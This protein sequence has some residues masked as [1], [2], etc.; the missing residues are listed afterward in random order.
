MVS[1]PTAGTALY[2]GKRIIQVLLLLILAL[3]L[4]VALAFAFNV[5]IKLSRFAPFISHIV[6]SYSG[7]KVHIDGDIL[8]TL[9][10]TTELE[11]EGIRWQEHDSDKL[12][13]L[14]LERGEA[15]IDVW[16]LFGPQIIIEKIAL[17]ALDLNLIVEKGME[18]NI[19]EVDLIALLEWIN[20]RAD[21]IPPFIADDIVLENVS[22]LFLAPEKNLK[23]Q[24][25]FDHINAAW[26]WDS[27]LQ[28]FGDGVLHDYDPYPISIAAK[29]G[30]FKALGVASKDW[31][32]SFNIAGNVAD[33]STTLTLSAESE[34]GLEKGERVLAKNRDYALKV[35]VNKFQYGDVLSHMGVTDAGQGYLNARI[36][37]QGMLANL[38][39]PLILSTGT[40]E[41]AV[42]PSG[43][44]ANPLDFWAINII[45]MLFIGLNEDSKVN[46]AVARFDLSDATLTSE[47]LIFD[48]SRL[49]VYGS[50]H[51]NLLSRELDFWI[52]AKAKQLQWLSKEVPV[53]IKGSLDDPEI[54][55]KKMGIFKSAVKSVVNFSLPLLPVLINDTME[56]DGSKDCLMSMKADSGRIKE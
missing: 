15:S 27:P 12:P 48:T 50:G 43:L 13:F 22:F 7:V 29:G 10:S 5:T 36:I 46:C 56:S 18:F 14:K 33:I 16:S 1:P 55:L 44:K 37:L 19:P 24:L 21:K 30:P 40:I 51:I 53:R 47:A 8:L 31:T 39:H 11:T 32:S 6:E 41:I 17:S 49:R 4:L 35:K 38:D 42:W 20:Y 52:E 45:N 25:D 2:I 28:L 3:L 34:V 26:G 9:G 54:E 23:G